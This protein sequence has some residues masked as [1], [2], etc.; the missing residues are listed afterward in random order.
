MTE[1]EA[2]LVTT[3]TNAQPPNAVIA[4]RARAAWQ[5]PAYPSQSVGIQPTNCSQTT[6]TAP[7]TNA[8]PPNAVIASRACAAR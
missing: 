7:T 5:S 2:P 8:Q 1:K 3:T 4:S 6:N